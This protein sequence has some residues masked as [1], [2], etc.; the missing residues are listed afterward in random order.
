MISIPLILCMKA[1]RTLWVTLFSLAF[2]FVEAS[3]VVYLRAIYYPGGFALPL[4]AISNF[5]LG[6]EL[7]REVGTMVMLAAVGILSGRTRWGRVSYFLIAFGVW[8]IFYYVWLKLVLNWPASVFDWDVL[9]LIPIPWIGPVI[10]P[11]LVSLFMIVGGAIVVRMERRGTEFH[12]TK[13]L[14]LLTVLGS[15]SILFSFMCDFDATLRSLPPRSY[16]YPLLWFGL[17][18]YVGA[19]YRIYKSGRTKCYS[20][21][22]RYPWR[23]SGER[24]S[25]P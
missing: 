20:S 8:D 22:S 18:C 12:P 25:S 10:A 11:V 2:A 4:K 21:V 1:G 24:G 16:P 6:V 14:W 17:I 7:T 23:S 5:H 3:V 9:F 13:P 15:L 19:L